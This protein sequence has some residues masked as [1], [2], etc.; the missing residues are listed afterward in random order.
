MR[1]NRRRNWFIRRI[2]LGF[3]VAAFVAPAAQ[4]RVDE[5]STTQAKVENSIVQAH[6]Y[7]PVQANLTAAGMPR[8]LPHD[9][10]LGTPSPHDPALFVGTQP[11]RSAPAVSV[12]SRFGHPN[13][14]TSTE[15]EAVNWND[16]GIGAGFALLLVLLGGGAV[17]ASRQLGH[18]QTA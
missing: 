15:L 7:Q 16:A 9:P 1:S 17:L 10:A 13:A 8:P 12:A 11:E 5:G 4:A 2:A 18:A 14:T 3:A 6:T